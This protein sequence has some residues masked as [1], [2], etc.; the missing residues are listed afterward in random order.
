M[1]SIYLPNNNLATGD[2]VVYQ[3]DSAISQPGTIQ[4]IAANGSITTLDSTVQDQ[5]IGGLRNDGIYYVVEVDA[6]HIRLATSRANAFNAVPIAFG[7]AG[8]GTGQQIAAMPLAAG[9]NVDANLT[10]TVISTAQPVPITIPGVL[11]GVSGSVSISASGLSVQPNVSLGSL[12]GGASAT[13]GTSGGSATA[14][15]QDETGVTSIQPA[16]GGSLSGAGSVVFNDLQHTVHAYV[17]NTATKA[18]PA[19]LATTGDVNVDATLTERG[20][21]LARSAPAKTSGS[22]TVALALAVNIYTNDSEA[23]V[24]NPSGGP[25]S[26]AADTIIDAGGSVGVA[27]NL[28][29]PF[30][31]NPATIFPPDVWAE[32]QA[33]SLGLPTLDLPDLGLHVTI[34]DPAFP[35][36]AVPDLPNLMADIGL[37]GLSIGSLPGLPSPDVP[38]LPTVNINGPALPTINVNLPAASL[39]FNWL[40]G[41]AGEAPSIENDW[42]QT[43]AGNSSATTAITGQIGVNLYNNTSQA[44][45]EGGVKVNQTGSLQTEAQS[46]AVTAVTSMQLVDIAGSGK[47][48]PGAGLLAAAAKAGKGNVTAFINGGTGQGLGGSVMVTSIADDTEALIRAGAQ[49]HI[50]ASGTLAVNA[51]EDIIRLEVSQSGAGGS[52]LAFAGSGD[53]YRQRST[54]LAGLTTSASQG[55]QVSGGG[56]VTIDA[57]S[58]GVQLGVAGGI[59][60]GDPGGVGV[61]LSAVVNDIGRTTAGFIGPD[62][63]GADPAATAYATL[64]GASTISASTVSVAGTTTGVV[65]S[66]S[67]AGD[68]TT[69]K[70]SSTPNSQ[71]DTTSGAAAPSQ[72]DT[73]TST[74]SGVGVAAGAVVNVIKD[75]TLGYVS[76]AGTTTATALDVSAT[77]GVDAVA[78]S[79]GVA[80]TKVGSSTNET[81]GGLRLGGAFALN[82]MTND[83][84]AFVAGGTVTA[85]T[86]GA[87]AITIDAQQAGVALTGSAA[88]TR[89][90]TPEGDDIAG[91][92][93]VNRIT[94]TTQAVMQNVQ[95]VRAAD[96]SLNATNSAWVIAIGGGMAGVSG[97][98][99]VGASIGYNQIAASTVAGILDG[100]SRS[101][102]TGSGTLGIAAVNATQIAAVGI[103]AGISSSDT[104]VAAA[105]TLGIN[106][107]AN[108]PTAYGAANA[109]GVIAAIDNATVNMGGAAALTARDGST[110]RSLS[111]AYAQG[112][113]GT[114]FGA[115]LAWNQVALNIAATMDD[116]TLSAASLDL[117]ALATQGSDL[118]DGR[119]SS[120]AVGA[121]VAGVAADRREPG[122]Q[123]R[124][125]HDRRGH[126]RRQFRDHRRHRLG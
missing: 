42:V 91:S 74:K 43:T 60:A 38:P 114:G 36:I 16:G 78:I 86:G 29:Y 69:S 52:N 109:D 124:A 100:G 80:L 31:V 53:G 33:F 121:A 55:V 101:A 37:P 125:E 95:V 7:S 27:S 79:G 45:I 104:S 116:A 13:D 41:T 97:P 77:D 20:Q 71:D 105:F 47:W 17:G 22:T 111:G 3:T 66:L 8:S 83:V 15:P 9:I 23:I 72:Y 81:Q 63:S 113:S 35:D 106:I 11:G 25:A 108:S 73:A 58:G 10:D 48:K 110:I 65:L 40:D 67:V 87:T 107:I 44:L 62:P 82:Q 39:A 102:I 12:F 19:T 103:S 21:A 117:E 50:G 64:A 70:A 88:L 59:V 99:G 49:V 98:L 112:R 89:D 28:D 126:Q 46:I 51:A 90:K 118:I 5:P 93:S 94:D 119:I 68:T 61:G 92:A 30:L 120:I 26:T 54:T 14:L 32:L 2:E 34:P 122:G 123:W 6:N 96:I 1:N 57:L 84:E 18:Q 75:T 85:L 56:A 76:T 4:E 115:A 24:G